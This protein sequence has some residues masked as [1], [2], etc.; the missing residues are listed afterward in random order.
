MI[1]EHITDKPIIPLRKEPWQMTRKEFFAN[2]PEEVDIWLVEGKPPHRGK[3]GSSPDFFGG[4]PT[5]GYRVANTVTPFDT[6]HK[7]IVKHALEEGKP[8]PSEVLADYVELKKE[9]WRMTRQE[10]TNIE[11]GWIELLPIPPG[12]R[13]RAV[14]HPSPKKKGYI[15]WSLIELNPKTGIWE[16]GSDIQFRNREE[17]RKHLEI[18][19]RQEVKQAIREGKSVPQEVLRDYPDL[20]GK[21]NSNHIIWKSEH[22]I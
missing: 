2:P 10:F 7:N 5:R 12:R 11:E 20:T 8:I 19:H 17:L 4:P 13:E 15:Q 14:I 16:P 22:I 9:P 1:E 21:V 6:A 18:I 3:I